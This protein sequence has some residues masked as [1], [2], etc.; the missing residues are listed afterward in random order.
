MPTATIQVAAVTA[1]DQWL[2]GAGANKVVAV[3]A[4][5][6]DAASYIRTPSNQY[7]QKYSLAANAIPPAAII[8]SIS[9]FSRVMKEGGVAQLWNTSLHLG[10]AS[11]N[12][13]VHEAVTSYVWVEYTDVISRPGGGG[14]TIGDITSLE[15]SIFS[16][17][18][19]Y[20]E[21]CTSLWLIV[22]YTPPG[23]MFQVFQP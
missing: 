22:D 3:N 11:A 8:N 19:N 13:T 18:C 5:T 20:Q 4:P 10:A 16:A 6:D 17:F 14:W 15:V 12:G 7:R 23:L 9:V 2:L 21:R 1:P